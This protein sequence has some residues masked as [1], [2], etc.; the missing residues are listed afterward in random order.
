MPE[1][2]PPDPAVATAEAVAGTR[3]VLVTGKGGVGKTTTAAALA[4]SAAR[5]GL[6]TLV[7]STDV[8]H[9]LGDALDIPLHTATAWSETTPV[10]DRLA[11]QAVG[12]HTSVEASW[13]TVQGYL[14]DVLDSVGVDA[15]VAEEL[16]SLPGADELS[17]LLALGHQ[18]RSGAWDVVV[19]DC[20]PTAETLRLLALPEIVGWHLDRL[21]PAQR[22]ML[23]ALRPAAAAATGFPLPGPDVLAVV[24]AW[25]EQMEQVRALLTSSSASVR[26]VLTPEKVVIAEARRV[27]TALSLHGYAVDQVIVNRVI[28]VDDGDPWRS[29]WNAAQADGL[30][31][32]RESVHG[33]PI[34]TAPFL[35][36]EPTG[37]DDL[38]ALAAAGRVVDGPT[39]DLLGPV[40]PPG[41]TVGAD[42]AE[43]V[44]TLPIPLVRS[45][46]VELS[47]RED[48]L[49]IEVGG[50]RRVVALPSVLRRCIV[51]NAGVRRG[52]LRVRFARDEEVWPGGG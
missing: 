17:A 36:G 5:S 19:V 21:L 46:E 37:T 11:A 13:E 20:A 50:Q 32:I 43:F 16:T 40:E 7:M 33:I 29:A 34:L 23:T 44:L 22:R 1:P 42:G 48:D 30:A 9:S 10:E 18:V 27:L 28:P 12:A 41:I 45:E 4:V 51:K 26:L 24:M 6:R 49:L 15:V 39:P 35:A 25:R 8:A 14:L 3:V 31:L 47:R 52:E 38:A 2:S